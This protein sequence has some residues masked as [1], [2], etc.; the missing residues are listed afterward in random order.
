MTRKSA[1]DKADIIVDAV[2]PHIDVT[3]RLLVAIAGPPAAGKST[4]A[5][6]VVEKLRN[7]GHPTGLMPMDGFHM[8]NAELK[9]NGTFERKGAPETFD[10]ASFSTVIADLAKGARVSIPSFDRENDCTVPDADLIDTHLRAVVIEGNYLLLDAPGW[11]DLSRYWDVSVF[12]DEDLDELNNRLLSRWADHGL[13]HDEALR[14]T[15]SNDLPNA[16]H[17]LTHRLPC[18]LNISP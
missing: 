2:Q 16:E 15:S 12:I 6:L 17:V 10:L 18:T 8:S 4:V 5:E 1:E 11:R 13:D 7:N 3:K 9:A 14:R